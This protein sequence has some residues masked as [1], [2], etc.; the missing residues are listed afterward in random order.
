MTAASAQGA[1]PEY[2]DKKGEINELRQLLRQVAM[3]R[4]V[5]KKRDAIKK[6]IGF[7]LFCYT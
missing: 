5:T 2:F 3:E 6:V 7:C 1:S 4:D